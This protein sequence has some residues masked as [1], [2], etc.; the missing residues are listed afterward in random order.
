MPVQRRKLIDL[1]VGL[2][3]SLEVNI[4]VSDIS[5]FADLS[6]D[7]SPLHIDKN[8]AIS[9]GF[10]GNV[11]H[12]AMIVAYTSALIG[13]KLPGAYGILQKMDIDFRAPLIPPK[14]IVIEGEITNIST[15]T[16]QITI[17]IRVIDSLK[18]ML[19]SG[20]AKSIV[21]E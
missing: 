18:K 8:F 1:H 13:N 14:K 10:D 9:R 6:G 5:R 15:S 7:V 2:K 3:E 21:R 12:G 11:A 17:K 20:I 19:A 4:D 16:G